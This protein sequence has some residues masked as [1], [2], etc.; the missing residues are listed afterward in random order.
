MLISF[1][2]IDLPDNRRPLHVYKVYQDH[3][4]FYQSYEYFLELDNNQIYRY[5]SVNR[6]VNR[7]F[8]LRLL[9][10]PTNLYIKFATFSSSAV[11]VT[12]AIPATSTL[13]EEAYHGTVNQK[14]HGELWL[15]DDVVEESQEIQIR[16]HHES[17]PG[18]PYNDERAAVLSERAKRIAAYQETFE[19]VRYDKDGAPITNNLIPAYEK[20]WEKDY[21]QPNYTA[22]RPL[23]P[24]KIKRLP[25]DFIYGTTPNTP[26][27][28]GFIAE[29]INAMIDDPTIGD[30]YSSSLDTYVLKSIPGVDPDLI[31]HLIQEMLAT[32]KQNLVD[33]TN[34]QPVI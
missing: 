29:T 19:F 26:T 10:N 11:L 30:V 17:Y 6:V 32:V 22:Y 27:V 8:Q 15:P 16:V 33:T 18:Y 20:P 28:E 4:L 23:T 34:Y 14:G 9:L 12:E 3:P 2:D 21:P 7:P 1:H 13:I 5:Q 25:D 24:E 31:D